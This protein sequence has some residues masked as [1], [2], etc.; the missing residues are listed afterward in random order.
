MANEQVKDLLY[1]ALETELGGVEVYRTAVACARNEE[2][3]EE[4][5]KYGEQTERHVQ[6]LRGVF[7]SLGLDPEA[8]TPGRTIVRE[9]GKSLVAA[10]K[11]ALKDAPEGA[12]IVAAEC[13]V[14]AETK[15]HRNWELIGVLG[16]KMTG[17]GREALLEAYEQVEDEED[18]HLYHTMGW[19]RELW[20]E[21]L[22]LPAMM[23]PPE[24][25]EDVESAAEEA[26]VNV[27]RTAAVKRNRRQIESPQQKKSPG[28]RPRA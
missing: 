19:C 8:T 16:G 14:D 27:K 11:R 5:T 9:K 28:K 24:E 25:E 1:Q 18:E 3:K 13:V 22:G 17:D 20:L 10:M 2:L 26:K 4:W 21:A 15:D 23:P 6:I 7:D 12:Q